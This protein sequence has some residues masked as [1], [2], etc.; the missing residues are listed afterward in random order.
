MKVRI[1]K[2]DEKAVIPTYAKECDAGL[3]L[4]NSHRTSLL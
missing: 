3:D 2:L 4:V 1:K